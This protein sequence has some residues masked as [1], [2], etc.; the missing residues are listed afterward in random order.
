MLRVQHRVRQGRAI[1][2]RVQDLGGDGGELRGD[3]GLRGDDLARDLWGAAEDVVVDVG[4]EFVEE[5]KG[6]G[7]DGYLV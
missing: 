6:R 7:G 5:G 2:I 4:G 3:R 1:G